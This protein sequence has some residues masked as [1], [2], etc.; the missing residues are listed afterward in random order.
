[1]YRCNVLVAILAL[2]ASIVV[3]QVTISSDGNVAIG[4]TVPNSSQQ[5]R[6]EC[7]S[8]TGTDRAGIYSNVTGGVYSGYSR[9]IWGASINGY[10]NVGVFGQ[11]TNGYS[12]YGIIGS[13][14][15]A[16]NNWAGWFNGNVYTTGSYSSSD[17]RLKKNI[18]PLESTLAKLMNL[19][20][21]RYEFL[22]EEELKTAGLPSLNAS[23]SDQIGL[24]AQHLATIFPELVVDVVHPND[25][26]GSDELSTTKAV[27]YDA[28]IAV[29]ISAIQ[30]QQARIEALEQALEKD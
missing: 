28:L 5:V 22:T 23:R 18:R 25:E 12:A 24:L 20:P 26:G 27:N 16:S 1:M 7:I 14:S 30:E 10:M 21:V 15:G 17:E 2:N 13:A 6:V 8:C 4:E 11:A 3:G 9:G 19:Q 29:L